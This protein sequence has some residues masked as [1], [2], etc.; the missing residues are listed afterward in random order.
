[1][2]DTVKERVARITQRSQYGPSATRRQAFKEIRAAEESVRAEEQEK[3]QKLVRE[4]CNAAVAAERERCAGIAEFFCR[5]ASPTRCEMETPQE[6]KGF[7]ARRPLSGRGDEDPYYAS[8]CVKCLVSEIRAAD[9][10]A[11]TK[12]RARCVAKA[13]AVAASPSLCRM[14]RGGRLGDAARYIAAAIR[15]EPNE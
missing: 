3:Y 5:Y 2:T 14:Y 15:E 1:M 9:E 6:C 12:E 8:D 10:A 7:A 11:T 4:V 13:R